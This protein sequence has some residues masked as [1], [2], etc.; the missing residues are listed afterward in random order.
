MKEWILELL[1]QFGPGVWNFWYL[2]EVDPGEKEKDE[3]ADS[4][5]VYAVWFVSSLF[6]K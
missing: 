2:E 1:T 5:A 6:S 3:R 4:G